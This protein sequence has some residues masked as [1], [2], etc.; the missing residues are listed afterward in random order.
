MTPHA[1]ILDR[2]NSIK[3]TAQRSVERS[4]LWPMGTERDAQYTELRSGTSCVD[5]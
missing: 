4:W 2:D 1:R 5:V 3:S